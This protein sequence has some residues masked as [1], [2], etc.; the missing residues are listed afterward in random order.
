MFIELKWSYGSSRVNKR[1]NNA[2]CLAYLLSTLISFSRESSLPFKAFLSIILT[3]YIWLGLS[4]LSASRTTEKAPLKQVEV[5][6]KMSTDAKH[7]LTFPITLSSS[8]CR[9]WKAACLSLSHLFW[10]SF[11]SQTEAFSL[12]R[13]TT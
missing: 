9:R 8:I 6:R 5:R 2:D 7:K 4:L 12:L 10:I 11:P 1:E 3:A 13:S